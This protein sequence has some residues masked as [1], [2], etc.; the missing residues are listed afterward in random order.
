MSREDAANTKYNHSIS[1]TASTPTTT[2][3]TCTHTLHNVYLHSHSHLHVHAH[4]RV[5]IRTRLRPG[6][7]TRP[8]HTLPY[9][10]G[11][12]FRV[13]GTPPVDVH[14]PRRIR[15]GDLPR[16]LALLVL[17]PR[18]FVPDAMAKASAKAAGGGGAARTRWRGRLRRVT[19][20]SV[21]RGV[22]PSKGPSVEY[23]IMYPCYSRSG[24]GVG[25]HRPS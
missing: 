16:R 14:A 6:E 3:H 24:E 8:W 25:L 12:F 15:L 4:M 7:R 18:S 9:I 5:Y 13:G 19:T 1:T 11:Y 21:G 22:P 10:H 17:H 20:H 23:R 2:T